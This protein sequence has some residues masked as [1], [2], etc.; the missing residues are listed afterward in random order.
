[1]W[2]PHSEQELAEFCSPRL[3]R[4]LPRDTLQGFHAAI[5]DDVFE[6]LSLTGALNARNVI[7]GTAP[8][9]ARAQIERHWAR[10]G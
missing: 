5:G 2:P 4:K 6:V 1:V 7:G 3:R 10:L 9:Q 8:N